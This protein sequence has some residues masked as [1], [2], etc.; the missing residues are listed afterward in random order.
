MSDLHTELLLH[1]ELIGRLLR[2][3]P[4]EQLGAFLRDS[5]A[6]AKTGAK[7]GIAE[8]QPNLTDAF[9]RIV[10]LSKR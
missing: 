2:L 8:S 3:V 9:A 6:A 10:M 1:R 4:P 5:E 7:M